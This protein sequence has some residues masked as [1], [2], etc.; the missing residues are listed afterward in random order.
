MNNKSP[1]DFGGIS[2]RIQPDARTIEEVKRECRQHILSLREKEKELTTLRAMV[3]ELEEMIKERRYYMEKQ[4]A[5]IR[6]L[7]EAM[8][9]PGALRGTA[10]LLKAHRH[11]LIA[12][13]LEDMADRI[14]AVMRKGEK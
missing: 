11:P 1:I 6:E 10:D 2:H 8:P 13:Q 12:G 9:S 4:S 5:S 7:E 14:D 3:K